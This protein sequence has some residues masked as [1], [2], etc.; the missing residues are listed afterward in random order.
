MRHLTL[1]YHTPHFE[2]CY[3]ISCIYRLVA[4]NS[5]DLT[6]N[7][8]LRKN[9][10]IT[11]QGTIPGYT[12]IGHTFEHTN[13]Y[14]SQSTLQGILFQFVCLIFMYTT[15]TR[16]SSILNSGTFK[17]QHGIIVY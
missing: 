15:L 7:W 9:D 12:M 2:Y 3:L 4:S 14:F 8:R 13:E 6:L 11:F 16:M 1:S 5:S 10:G 17:E